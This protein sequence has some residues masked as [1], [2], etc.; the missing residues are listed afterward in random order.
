MISGCFLRSIAFASLINEGNLCWSSSSFFALQCEFSQS[1]FSSS[2]L[3][4]LFD[5]LAESSIMALLS[6]NLLCFG[7][8]NT[9]ATFISSL[10]FGDELLIVSM[11]LLCCVNDW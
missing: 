7:S 11:D 6:G 3:N 4:N 1:I 8:A 5:L 2:R 9:F 10:I